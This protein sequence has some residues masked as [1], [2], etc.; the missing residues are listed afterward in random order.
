ME[1]QQV[2]IELRARAIKLGL[3]SSIILLLLGIA[4][5]IT[6]FASPL[7]APPRNWGGVG[8][9]TASVK[10]FQMFEISMLIGFLMV[11]LFIGIIVS[12]HNY[13][14]ITKKPLTHMA[15]MFAAVYAV[16]VSLSYFVELTVIRQNIMR[17][18]MGL[19]DQYVDTIMFAIDLLGFFFLGLSMSFT[20]HVFAGG[21]PEA[22]LRCFLISDGV[23]GI[24]GV[25]GFALS[26]KILLFI[27]LIGISVALTITA[28]LLYIF[29][30]KEKQRMIKTP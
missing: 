28:F 23:L 5:I 11:P 8:T 12:I 16:L 29:F 15:L 3:W 13:A 18:Q 30:K 6:L 26:N 7:D 4:F 17:G 1:E 2:E 10:T 9:F 27:N 25:V 20:A 22:L 14:P 24:T 21:K 19:L